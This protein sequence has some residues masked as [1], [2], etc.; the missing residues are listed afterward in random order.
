M[1]LDAPTLR[2]LAVNVSQYF[3]DFLES[4]FKK[5][6]A[7][8]RRITLQT[9]SGFRA[10]MRVAP[11]PTLQTALW[12]LLSARTEQDAV[13]Q[14]RP[15]EHT[16]SISASLRK[17][18][19][20]QVLA[21]EPRI[22]ETV[23]R[24]I[25]DKAEATLSEA[26]QNP[27]AWIDQVRNT[28][29]TS[30]STEVVRPL[31]SY[32]DG[33]LSKQAYSAMDS[34]FS[35]EGDL[36]GRAGRDLDEVLPDVLAK[37]IAT[38]DPQPLREAMN[39]FLTLEGVQSALIGYFQDFVSADAFL[40]FRD[41]ETYAATTDGTQLYLYVGALKHRN[42][43]YPLFFLPLSVERNADSPNYHVRALNH[44]YANRRAIDFALQELAEP[45]GRVWVNPIRD[46][47]TYLTP[48]QSIQEVA[49]PL[50]RNVAAAV[51]MPGQ[52]E[53][54]E[55]AVDVTNTKIGLSAALHIAAFERADEALLN[56]YEEIISLA[57]QGGSA[58]VNLFE[59]DKPR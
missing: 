7:P 35:A 31:L 39:D 8:R 58:I 9:D 24:E 19:E 22:I 32:L 6:Q 33:P 25:K 48:D 50:F 26:I 46:R 28:L 49:R 47:I 18:I 43:S 17:V 40:E 44:L 14:I 1:S 4:D 57:R 2:E 34:I 13:L 11:Y 56:D 55:T 3:L 12:K 51:D 53:L 29:A 27:E 16:R 15:H 20:E 45:D 52:I 23:R 36:I 42:V 38:R 5:Q 41:V 30:L 59:N 21:I 10:G 54:S 37:F